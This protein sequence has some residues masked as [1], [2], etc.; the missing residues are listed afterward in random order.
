LET[1]S[2]S[3]EERHGGMPREPRDVVWIHQLSPEQPGENV[4]KR[5]TVRR[6]QHEQAPGLEQDLHRLEKRSGPV[7]V[8]DELAGDHHLRRFEPESTQLGRVLAIGLVRNETHPLGELD[9]FMVGIDADELPRDL[10][11]LTVQPRAVLVLD[12]H[13]TDVDETEVDDP[14]PAGELEEILA[15]VDE[16]GARDPV[17]G[18]GDLLPAAQPI[19]RGCI[20]PQPQPRTEG[21]SEPGP[22]LDG[23]ETENR[24]R[25][26]IFAGYV[27]LY[28]VV[29][30]SGL[31]LLRTALDSASRSGFVE[32]FGNPRFL[33]GVGLY[34]LGFVMWLATLTRYQ[35]SLVYPIFV[36]VG[37]CAVV[38]AA[39][40][41]LH[42]QASA[43]KV[44][45]IVL[46]AVGLVFVVR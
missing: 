39:F 5:R 24:V 23:T 10:A 3:A 45:G 15:S 26:A 34:A 36:G 18:A 35:L 21:N 12:E 16:R 6:C 13:P 30:A 38:L 17:Y 33:G 37:Y 20:H 44:T 29:N 43:A 2:V 31:L 28:A 25:A 27:A 32:L 11:K 46:V 14:L 40:L 41:F 1:P 42:E 8:L 22:W 4:R 9:P 19:V 7:E